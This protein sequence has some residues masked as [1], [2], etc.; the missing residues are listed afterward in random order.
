MP[1]V[2]P[3]SPPKAA[4]ADIQQD[5]DQFQPVKFFSSRGRVGRLRYLAY[6]TLAN[7]LASLVSAVLTAIFVSARMGGAGVF[8][9]VLAF[10]LFLIYSIFLSIQ[11]SHDMDWSG[12]TAPLAI[13]PFAALIW[14]FKGGTPGPNRFGPPPPPNTIMV[15]I[16]GL[17]LPVIAFVGILAAIVLPAYV[18]YAQRAKAAQI[19]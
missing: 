6:L 2:N 16:V 9:G 3:Y 5:A 12:W 1:T 14:I 11:R 7:I 17:V 19:R 8:I 10:V 15:K 4:V 13:I 18:Q